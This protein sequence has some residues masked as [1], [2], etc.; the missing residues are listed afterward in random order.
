MPQHTKEI[1][2]NLDKP[3]DAFTVLSAGHCE[4]GDWQGWLAEDVA[5]ACEH[6]VTGKEG[7]LGGASS[8]KNY[9]SWGLSTTFECNDADQIRGFTCGAMQVRHCCGGINIQP[10][11]F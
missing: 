9:V 10:L 5:P 3:N 11:F 7:T 4:S 1:V 8:T 6:G 2:N